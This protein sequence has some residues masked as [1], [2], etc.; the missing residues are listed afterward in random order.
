MTLPTIELGLVVCWG[1][2]D[3]EAPV[4]NSKC[5]FALG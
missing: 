3:S 4:T 5:C 2:F 1:K